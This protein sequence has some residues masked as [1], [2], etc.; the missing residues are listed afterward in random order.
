MIEDSILEFPRSVEIR[1]LGLLYRLEFLELGA[2]CVRGFREFG[3]KMV[4]EKLTGQ[5]RFA[6]FWYSM[7][8]CLV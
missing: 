1:M 5:Q 2:E 8:L 6:L 3:R 4:W 7:R